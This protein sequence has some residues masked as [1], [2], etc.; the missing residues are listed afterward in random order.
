MPNKYTYKVPFTPDQ[1]HSD[2][3]DSVMSQDEIGKK[4][5]VSQ[6]VVHTAMKR[7]GFLSR[8]A[9]PRNQKMEANNNWKGGSYLQPQQKKRQLLLGSGY[10]MIYAPDHRHAQSAGYV[11]EH[12]LIALKKYNLDEI[13]NGFCVHHINLI[14]NDN[15]PGNLCLMTRREHALAHNILEDLSII[16]LLNTGKIEFC[17]TLKTY[18]RRDI[19]ESS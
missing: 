6:K 17:E 15:D 13:P 5:G 14:K 16:M 12:I 2:Y 11:Y 8:K 1:L 18:V 9:A 3:Y 4:W 19:C 10:R 7:C